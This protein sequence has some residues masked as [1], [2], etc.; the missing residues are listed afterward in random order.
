MAP[1]PNAG[2]VTPDPKPN[3]GCAPPYPTLIGEGPGVLL[4]LLAFP[5]EQLA[6]GD[7]EGAVLVQFRGRS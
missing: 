1:E 3:T 5:A 6:A 2:G 4:L 7:R